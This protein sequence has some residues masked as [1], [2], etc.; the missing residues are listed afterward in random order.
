M[1]IS[2]TAPLLAVSL[3]TLAACSG[4][5]KS[6]GS[7]PL[8]LNALS[9]APTG[10]VQQARADVS[11]AADGR[12]LL[13][14]TDG[15]MAGMSMDC[16]DAT[17]GACLV[18]GGPAG[19][20]ANGTILERYRGQYA[21]VGNFSVLQ[22]SEGAL[23]SSSHLVHDASP[24]WTP[25]SMTLPQGRI[26]YS[27]RFSAGAGLASGQSGMIEGTVALVADF[28]EAVLAG[29]LSGGFADG[30]PVSASFNN[31][32]INASNGYFTTTENSVILFQGNVANGGIDGAFY[33]PDAQEAAGIFQFGNEAGGM[34]GIFLAC[35][36]A[37]ATCITP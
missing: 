13:S 27:G 1:S 35:Q 10:T 3:L 24:D 15:P 30:T 20:T 14:I 25:T 23:V 2:P 29:Q 28:N 4:G 18:V 19:T 34:S 11:R 5:G 7:T 17:L 9:S 8:P 33:G 37:D 21:F 12:I 31:L 6:G 32:T 16:A 22:V 26:S 36:G